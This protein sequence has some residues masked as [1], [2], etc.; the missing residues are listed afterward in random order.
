M[1]GTVASQSVQAAVPAAVTSDPPDDGAHPPRMVSVRI[2]T[3]GVKING[4]FYVAG[5]A[6]KHPT[7]IFFKGLPGNE[8]NLDLAQAVRRA[9]WN[10]LT[11][12]F[13]GSWGSP[14]TYSYRHQLEDAAAA[15]DFLRHPA[16]DL[17]DVIDPQRI[18]L[19]GHSTGG[20]IGIVTAASRTDITA[21]VVISASDD[22][23]DAAVTHPDPKRW[24]QYLKDNFEGSLYPLVGCTENGLAM[25]ALRNSSSWSFSAAAPHLT[26]LPLLIVTANDG[27][28]P[29]GDALQSAV[30]AHGGKLVSAVHMNTD[31][32]YSDHRIAL[33]SAVVNWL[34]GQ[35]SKTH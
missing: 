25:E 26:G 33:E 15:I 31:H 34:Q 9:G 27:L 24:K 20:M 16:S 8:Q 23:G 6:G 35:N 7:L 21:L 12:H 3:H 14:G 32:A 13:R 30:I 5:G 29:T 22:A 2:P 1:A 11:M 19:A 4:V 17:T 10:V 18:V 28:A